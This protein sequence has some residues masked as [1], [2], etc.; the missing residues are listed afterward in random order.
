MELIANDRGNYRFLTGIAPYSS[1]AA[2]IEGYEIVHARLM[3]PIPY[4]RGFDFIEDHL[5]GLNRRRQALCGIELRSP[6]PFTFEGFAAL[7]KDYQQIL[8]DWDLLLDGLNPIARTN[9]AP[10]VAPPDEPVLFG[11][12][13]TIPAN[14]SGFTFVSAGGG[15]LKNA[16]L[17]PEAIVCPD[18]TTPEAMEQK[19]AF[20]IQSMENR[21]K[22]LGATW[23]QVTSV[24]V[25]TAHNIHPF[26][27]E[28]IL[29]RIGPAG[30][31]GL[32]WYYSRP[33]I[34]GVEFEMD[35]RGVRQ[36]LYLA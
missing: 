26:M 9:V 20:V 29:D 3:K 5:K 12:S 34:C 28:Q 2:A 22:G 16:S 15:E 7:N 23:S 25:Y 19:A 36:D 35:F 21:L 10:V 18:Q 8:T 30:L 24:S 6:A 13:Y 31:M 4:K 27:K 17:R 32:N 33:P 1:G 14:G 11:F